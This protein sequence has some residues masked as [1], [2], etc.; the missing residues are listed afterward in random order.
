[1][2]FNVK[3]GTVAEWT[4][5]VIL[6]GSPEI[7]INTV[8]TDSR[9]LG[10][11][12]LFIPIAGQKFDGHQFIEN[13]VK[14]KSIA[15]YLTMKK[16]AEITG[17]GV[18]AIKCDDTLKAYGRLASE[19]RNRMHAKIIGITGTN[20][21]TTT[22]EMLWAILNRKNKT[23]KNE[24]NYNNEIGVPYTLLGLKADHKFAV[25][26]MGMNHKGEI[27]ILSKMAKP[28]MAVITNV[29]EG[30]LEFLGN[31]ENVAIAK[32]EI[33]NG[34]NSGAIIILNRDT[35]YFEILN[36]KA[37][38]AGLEVRTFG[39]S[40]EADIKPDNYKM[41]SDS[42]SFEYKGVDFNVPVYGMHNLYNALAALA[43][44]LT[45]GAEINIVKDAFAGFKNV[46]MRSQMLNAGYTV[47]NDTYNSNPLS[48]RYALKSLRDVFP[49]KRK[50]A[51][52]SDMKELGDASEQYHIELGKIAK[53]LGIDML[54][55]WGEMAENIAR[56]ANKNGM[57]K[58]AFHFR[59][60]D[61][62]IAFALKNITKDDV[63]LVKG[64]RSMKMEEVVERLIH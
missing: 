26:E 12:S 63:V 34:M 38:D 62:L 5:G 11:D 18:G 23:Q 60:K 48:A 3:L 6:S 35:Q 33:I 27:D 64:S 51:I 28:D 55:T 46:D 29:G 8:T 50:I 14:S 42:V 52:L 24:K 36:K 2:D 53:S 32:S 37:L 1:M 19:H 57:D 49:G 21:K 17:E 47:I 9:E 15:A 31:V 40:D 20:G 61:E 22:K 13:L 16:D 59:T 30:H 56:G 10:R 44:A 39:L 4:G 54:L 7:D 25:I 58:N 41:F 43:A 45:L